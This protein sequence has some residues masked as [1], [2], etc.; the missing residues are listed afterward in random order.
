L[1]RVR[2]NIRTEGEHKEKIKDDVTHT[3]DK[4]TLLMT[5]AQDK[6]NKTIKKQMT[7]KNN[8]QCNT[9]LKKKHNNMIKEAENYTQ[10]KD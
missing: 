10:K 5:S 3:S 8:Q 7:T 1:D 6:E 4:I 2:H 9:S